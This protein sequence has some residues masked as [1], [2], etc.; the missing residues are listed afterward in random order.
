MVRPSYYLLAIFPGL[1]AVAGLLLFAF[2]GFA[3]VTDAQMPAALAKLASLLEHWMGWAVLVFLAT[4]FTAVGLLGALGLV[5]KQRTIERL[6]RQGRRA[7]GTIVD[8]VAEERVRISRKGG[9]GVAT[10][11][12]VVVEWTDRSG[13]TWRERAEP[14]SF[15]PAT[16]FTIGDRLPVL[17]DTNDAEEFWIDLYG[18]SKSAAQG[19]SGPNSA[20]V[21]RR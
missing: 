9:R 18:E 19:L 13:K 20:P 21:V 10:T 4:G 2:L 14:L 1:F 5:Q 17:V 16:K 8:F 12:H 15:N 7:E 3:L 6:L 11:W